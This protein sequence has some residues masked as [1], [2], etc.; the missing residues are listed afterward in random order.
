MMAYEDPDSNSDGFND[1]YGQKEVDPSED[2]DK[3]RF[4]ELYSRVERKPE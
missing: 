2:N 4:D 3:T 1:L